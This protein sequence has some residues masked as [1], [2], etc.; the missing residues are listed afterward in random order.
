M[1]KQIILCT[2]LSSLILCGCTN[3]NSSSNNENNSTQQ[4]TEAPTI[5]A[6][7]LSSSK[8]EDISNNNSK[9]PLVLDA[10]GDYS[11]SFVHIKDK[12]F[13]SDEYNNYKTYIFDWEDA[14]KVS[15]FKARI[16]D[17]HIQSKEMIAYGDLIIYSNM[18][19]NNYIYQYNATTD[20]SK[21]INN[22]SASSLMIDGSK[23][24]Y[25][26]KESNLCC[27][28][29]DTFSDDVVMQY[30]TNKFTL[31]KGYILYQSNKDHK[32][33]AFSPTTKDNF[34]IT[35][36]SVESFAVND[37]YIYCSNSSD[38][39]SLYIIN[40][41]TYEAMKINDYHCEQIKQFNKKIYFINKNDINY[42][43]VLQKNS[44]D[45]NDYTSKKISYD[46]INE[47]NFCDKSIFYQGNT[48]KNNIVMINE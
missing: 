39:D 43:H 38:G 18:K 42:L 32:L 26:D 15:N 37:G 17:A 31:T 12:L 11:S 40:P 28:S 16:S 30:K 3:N 1:K 6:P 21:R 45:Y 27:L 46:S 36:F 29:L 34:K 4:N 48:D 41:A 2:L 8:A 23:L 20:S 25:L 35:D 14:S 22:K 19:D 7:I 5:K 44:D 24:Y 10:V 33:Y 47:Y 13:A 9:S